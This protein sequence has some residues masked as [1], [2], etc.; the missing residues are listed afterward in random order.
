M[1]SLL[2]AG[3]FLLVNPPPKYFVIRFPECPALVFTFDNFEEV[4]AALRWHNGEILVEEFVRVAGRNA[5][6]VL[7][8]CRGVAA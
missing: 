3:F 5:N 2:L 1:K 7:I 8:E 6:R 4:L